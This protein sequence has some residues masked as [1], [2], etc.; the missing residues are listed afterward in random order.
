ME[1]NGRMGLGSSVRVRS[2]LLGPC[3][4]IVKAIVITATKGQQLSPFDYR[5]ALSLAWMKEK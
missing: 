3:V 4:A 2:G 5:T 1:R